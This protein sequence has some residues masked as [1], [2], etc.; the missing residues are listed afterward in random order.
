MLKC[1]LHIIFTCY[2]I[3]IVLIS[4]Q[5]CKNVRSCLSL[6]LCRN[7]GK[8]CIAYREYF[9]DPCFRLYY[10]LHKKCIYG[11]HYPWKNLCHSYIIQFKTSLY[12]VMQKHF[13]WMDAT[14]LFLTTVV[15]RCFTR[16]ITGGIYLQYYIFLRLSL[17]TNESLYR[18]IPKMLIMENT[19][20]ITTTDSL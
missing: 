19:T 13:Y 12:F 14:C 18:F 10:H 3:I 15:L 2:K 7:R 9:T 20:T 11:L 6:G 17:S 4:F 8:P 5:A 16:K 1:E